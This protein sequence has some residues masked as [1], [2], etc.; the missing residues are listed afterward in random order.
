MNKKFKVIILII[1]L[2]FVGLMPT[3]AKELTFD[4]L[5]KAVLE[6]A[7]DSSY[8]YLIGKYVFTST[9][10][11]ETNESIGLQ[12]IMLAANSIGI[13]AVDEI[14]DSQSYKKMT[15]HFVRKSGNDWIIDDNICGET[16]L[17]A[18]FRDNTTI[19]VWRI[20]Y[21]KLQTPTEAKLDV[22]FT[23]SEKYNSEYK[24]LIED[25]Y[26]FTGGNAANT[27]GLTYKDGKLT[28][29]LKKFDGDLDGAGF[30]SQDKTGYY[31]S[32]FVEFA[33]EELVNANSTIKIRV[34][35]QKNEEKVTSTKVFKKD[36]FDSEIGIAMLFAYKPQNISEYQTIEVTLDY[37]GEA[38]EEY[39]PYTYTID[40]SGLRI[41]VTSNA[42]MTN[43]FP[44]AD[45]EVFNGWNYTV[46]ETVKYI[47]DGENLKLEGTLKAQTIDNTKA[48]FTDVDISNYYVLVN[49]NSQDFIPGKTEI[50]IKKGHTEGVKLIKNEI[51]ANGATVL[52]SL[53]E[54]T[55]DKKTIEV[56]VDIDGSGNEWLEKKYTI[57]W[58]DLVLVKTIAPTVTDTIEG[59]TTS[60]KTTIQEILQDAGINWTKPED[61]SVTFEADPSD[62]HVIKVKGLLPKIDE[63]EGSGFK[64]EE[65]TGYYVP[66]V[67]K[68]DNAKKDSTLIVVPCK[69][70][71]GGTKE[72]PSKAFDTDKEVVG[73]ASVSPTK[74]SQKITIYYDGKNS[75]EYEPYTITLDYSELTLQKET[76]IEN[77]NVTTNIP[78]ADKQYFED[79]YGYKAESTPLEVNVEGNTFKLSGE[80]H[81]QDIKGFG[82]SAKT[83]FYIVYNITPKNLISNKTTITVPINQ[84]K[85][86]KTVVVEDNTGLSAIVS[87][88]KEKITECKGG[89]ADKCKFEVIV[90]LDGAEKEYTPTK[91]YIDYSGIT[92]VEYVTAKFNYPDGAKE[93]KVYKGETIS[94]DNEEV[95]TN[96]SKDYHEFVKWTDT[97]G[98]EFKI[99]ETKLEKS[100]TLNPNWKIKVND[101]VNAKVSE[102]SE[103]THYNKPTLIDKTIDFK[104][105]TNNGPISEF[106]EVLAPVIEEILK[107]NEFK[108]VTL[109]LDTQKEFTEANLETIKS[110]LTELLA[111]KEDLDDLID[112]E[113]TI[114][115]I[116]K[117]DALVTFDSE[118]SYKITF[119]ANF[120][121]AKTFEELENALTAA[122]TKEINT[123]YVNSGFTVTSPLKVEK[124]V[125]IIG[126]EDNITL[127]GN[128]LAN[129]FDVT[130]TGVEIKKLKLEGATSAITVQNAA[131]LT[132]DKLQFTTNE[133]P[134]IEVLGGSLTGTNLTYNGEKYDYPLVKANNGSNI[135]VTVGESKL[136]PTKKEKIIKYS[137]EGPVTENEIGDKKVDDTSYNSQYTNYYLNSEVANRWIKMRFVSDRSVT[138]FPTTYTL[139]Y[140]KEESREY[141]PEPA[142]DIEGFTKVT[143]K[144]IVHELRGWKCTNPKHDFHEKGKITIPT[145]EVT[146]YAD[147]IEKYNESVKKVSDERALQS[148]IAGAGQEEKT[149]IVLESEIPL[150]SVLD[151]NQ[152]NIIITGVTSGSNEIKGGLK[153]KIKVSA[154][155]ITFEKI[156]VTGSNE[157]TGDNLVEVVGTDFRSDHVT[158]SSGEGNY[159]NM[160]NFNTTEESVETI[161]YFNK[162]NLNNASVGI[163]FEK[164]VKGNTGS[165]RDGVTITGNDFDDSGKAVTF[166][167]VKNITPNTTLNIAQSTLLMGS[168][169]TYLLQINSSP[170]TTKEN[171]YFTNIWTSKS[172]CDEKNRKIKVKIN[173][174]EGKDASGIVL[175]VYKTASTNSVKVEYD[176]TPTAYATVQNRKDA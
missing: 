16:D 37:D 81:E 132:V 172:T 110:N 157:L 94:K 90:D 120:R 4:E 135:N 99:G 33:N 35:N 130:S 133:G 136:N 175:E 115:F 30:S 25:T 142:E 85:E 83:G 159:T 43:N 77:D 62:S 1:T 98:N 68:L 104:L 15:I 79:T 146:Y 125:T 138:S 41:P 153:G 78:T 26:G 52:I 149:V 66:F 117:E 92:I 116:K 61:Y 34:I 137:S 42:K 151:I 57:D 103:N 80:V 154:N 162:F 160:I 96:P 174:S 89:Q 23:K 93:V 167:K 48:G 119:S 106:V 161:L 109:N 141:A 49:I 65:I 70:C 69:S 50:K 169:D 36:Q 59:Q 74:E 100:L 75:K 173:E 168:N 139:Y 165:E 156:K 105:K 122:K 126:S 39:K 123:I 124:G 12:D 82:G 31:F 114:S 127:T 158:Y 128:G 150:T 111:G 3:M 55:S 176:G 20:N 88:Q 72:V 131:T 22:D 14:K 19:N 118:D 102:T 63:V 6:I 71:A 21:T 24:T 32:Y 113:I 112:K 54:T 73:L 44:A 86:D 56:T 11:K 147:Y 9:Y 152:K 164:E 129:I 87:I 107:T 38:G 45:L 13:D 148:A 166:I 10:G 47:E 144:V 121:E 134:A 143:G 76:I 155:D 170:S 95:K 97:E 84:D 8:Y 18:E 7:P 5:N 64:G 29:L 2:F 60:G 58:K 145:E 91:I 27:E 46:P 17:E 101:Y 108:N 53:A 140:D 67:I 171:F 28:G 40:L 163:N 51:D